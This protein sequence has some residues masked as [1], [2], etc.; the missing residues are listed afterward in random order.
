M[1]LGATGLSTVS[2][3][4]LKTLLKAVHAG[5]LA[6]PLTL[7]ELTRFGLQYVAEDLNHLRGL[8]ATAVK[9]VVIAVLAERRAAVQGR[10]RAP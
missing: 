5:D 8:D 7:P 6:C 10:M 3:D 1:Q 4:A 2:S 9:A